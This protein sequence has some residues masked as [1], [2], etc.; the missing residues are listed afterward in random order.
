MIAEKAIIVLTKIKDD[1]TEGLKLSDERFLT[2]FCNGFYERINF[3]RVG[4]A[5]K[6]GKYIYKRDY[7]ENINTSIIKDVIQA[8]FGAVFIDG[9]GCKSNNDYSLQ[10]I[11]KLLDLLMNKYNFCWENNP[12]SEKVYHCFATNLYF[13]RNY[14]IWEG[15]AED[16][17]SY[18][19]L[20][21][22]IGYEFNTSTLIQTA[23]THDSV[24]GI[25]AGVSHYEVLEFL[26]DAVYELVICEYLYWH[27]INVR[28]GKL[29]NF[30]T[31]TNFVSK[32]FQQVIAKGLE[33]DL[34]IIKPDH[35]KVNDIDDFLESIVGAIYVDAKTLWPVQ[36]VLVKL[37][38][39]FE[40]ET[41][42]KCNLHL[43]FA[44]KTCKFS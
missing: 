43:P 10:S 13:V 41:F 34:F 20:E 42:E 11:R 5:L 44:L 26:G 35:V 25:L 27:Y 31:I 22:R 18:K 4:Y 17:K 33:L 7:V 15:H 14:L 24:K 39:M 30:G 29:F 1:H 23:L 16:I 21:K 37:C 28:D 38:R 19:I 3:S 8:I 40:K 36:K 6:L 32:A 9:G 12:C 2:E